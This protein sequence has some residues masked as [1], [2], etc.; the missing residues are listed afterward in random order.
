VTAVSTTSCFPVAASGL[1]CVPKC[2]HVMVDIK[3][4]VMFACTD[5][6]CTAVHS[7]YQERLS[8]SCPGVLYD[9][10]QDGYCM[11]LQYS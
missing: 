9:M 7:I 11:I 8:H 10:Y 1:L 6:G 5:A 3:E 2:R 4:I